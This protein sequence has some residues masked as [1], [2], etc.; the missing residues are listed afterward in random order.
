MAEN[1]Q[2][3]WPAMAAAASA[4]E[5]LETQYRGIF[6][7]AKGVSKIASMEGAAREIEAK[8]TTLRG[9]EQAKRDDIE[10]LDA[11][12]RRLTRDRDA[13]DDVVKQLDASRKSLRDE[14]ARLVPEVEQHRSITAELP[15]LRKQH[16][17]AQAALMAVRKTLGV[18]P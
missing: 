12:V 18:S 16:A 4:L 9:L 11:G 14:L 13:L 10:A 7:L 6:E 17:E 8:L 5:R 3:N 1:E 2:I 15:G